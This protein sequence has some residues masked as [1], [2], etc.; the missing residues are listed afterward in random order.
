MHHYEKALR[1][2]LPPKPRYSQID[3]IKKAIGYLEEAERQ[4]AIR[5]RNRQENETSADLP[6]KM[7]SGQLKL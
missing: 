1:P 3:I 5:A 2:K 4:A 7:H 6:H